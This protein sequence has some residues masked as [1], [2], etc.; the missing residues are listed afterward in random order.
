MTIF[1]RGI[2]IERPI[3]ILGMA[4]S[5]TSIVSSI[6]K[7]HGIWC[8]TV[9]KDRPSNYPTGQHENLR[10]KRELITRYG[11]V[12]DIRK[13][14]RYDQDWIN[15]ATDILRKDKYPGG[16]WFVKHS[17]LYGRLWK[18]FNPYYI[19]IHRDS[20]DILN[21]IERKAGKTIDREFWREI[22]NEHIYEMSDI[23]RETN[24]PIVRSANLIEGDYYYLKH[25]FLYCNLIIDYDKVKKIIQPN[26]WGV[27]V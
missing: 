8:G 10:V 3:I 9:R 17:A 13:P 20:E 16:R 11:R 24:A 27:T 2:K 15:I 1:S 25:A 5:G 6:L 7:E 26:I 21:S 23:Y 18:D 19:C 22:I 4:R 12:E 14:V